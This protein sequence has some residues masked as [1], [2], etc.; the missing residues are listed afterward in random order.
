LGSGSFGFGAGWLT[1]G[2]VVPGRVE[3]QFAQE[4]AG[5]GVDDADVQ[6]V[7]EYQDGGPGVGPADADVVEPA[8]DAQGELAVGI[9]AVGAD[10][11]VAVAGPVAGGGFGAGC[12]S[13]GWRGPVRQGPVWP[14][15]VVDGGEGAQQGLELGDRGGLGS[16]GGQPSF[17]GLL[18]SLDFAL[19]LRVAGPAVLLFDAEAAQLGFEAVAATPPAGEPRREDQPVEFLSGV[20]E[21]GGVWS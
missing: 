15:L 2:L 11:V 14:L 16:L 18:E 12:I 1:G 20:K 5:G 8:V 7:D 3:G 13:G 10:A 21:F 19:G 9:D 6:V 17:E 4:F